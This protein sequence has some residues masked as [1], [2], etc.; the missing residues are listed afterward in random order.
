MKNKMYWG[1]AILILLLIGIIG[2]F[3]PFNRTPDEPDV[4]YH[5]PS[6]TSKPPRAE[7]DFEWEGHEDHTGHEDHEDH[8]DHGSEVPIEEDV[9]DDTPK[10]RVPEG[11]VTTPDFSSVPKDDDPV[12]AAYK[13]LEYIK[14]NPYAW[15]GVHSERATELIDQLMTESGPIRLIDHDHGE[16]VIEQISEL[17][18]QN[19]PRV[20][21]VLIGHMVDGD[22][23]GR[24]MS[25]ALDE[26]GPPAVPYILP[27]LEK[28]MDEGGYIRHAVFESLGS[29]G[30]RYRDDLGGI[31]DHIIIPKLEVI[32]ANEGN[33]RYD[34]VSVIDARRALE[35]L[36]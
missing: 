6:K 29:I 36:R 14:N 2:V 30:A 32:A 20:A 4:F 35:V 16:L 8:G 19:D 15:G 13:R 12:K 7:Q 23:V 18:R 21:A 3:L 34:V 22:T 10:G 27:Y 26:I 17:C 25:D 11:A 1:V 33:E 5:V 9:A 24:P 28:G 31:V